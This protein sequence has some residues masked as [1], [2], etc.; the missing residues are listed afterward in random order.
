MRF[1]ASLT[2]VAREHYRTNLR[3]VREQSV[4][5]HK[6]GRVCAERRSRLSLDARAYDLLVG[7]PT[8]GR[9]TIT[10]VL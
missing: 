8:A 1:C 9:A 10:S 3:A 7:A 6:R 5:V 4:T 2:A